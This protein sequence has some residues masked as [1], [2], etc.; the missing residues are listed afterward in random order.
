MEIIIAI[1]VLGVIGAAFAF[2]P[3][4]RQAFRINSD[5]AADSLTTA[6]ERQED[7]YKQLVAKLPAQRA[8][9]SRVMAQSSQADNDLTAAE[10][11]VAKVQQEYVNAKAANAPDSVLDTLATNWE[12]AKADAD[13]KRQIASELNDAEE[14]AISAL[15]ETTTALKRFGSQVEQGR[16]KAELAKALDVAAEARENSRNM[17]DSISRA[18]SA[19]REIDR[20]LEEARARNELSKGSRSDRELEEYRRQS[21]TKSARDALDALTGGAADAPAATETD[22][23]EG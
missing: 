10:A 11:E 18:G 5:K 1:V 19:A 13:G 2:S 12:T 9:V 15:E 23:S 20:A 17:K 14:E 21:A 22:A 3:K 8:A 7:E 16:A 6:N 4:L